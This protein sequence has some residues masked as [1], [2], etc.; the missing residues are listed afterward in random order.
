LIARGTRAAKGI[1]IAP[2]IR[3]SGRRR[4]YQRKFKGKRDLETR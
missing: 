4:V 2:N 3:K 1:Q